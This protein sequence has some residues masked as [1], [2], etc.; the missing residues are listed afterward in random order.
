MRSERLLAFACLLLVAPVVVQAQTAPECARYRLHGLSPGMTA[1]DVRDQMDE[2]G[3]VQSDKR[4]A[5]YNR[6]ESTIWVEFDDPIG[7]KSARLI[8]IRSHTG[9]HVD[10]SSVL[11]S[12]VE[13]LGAVGIF[14]LPK[15]GRLGLVV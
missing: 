1:R 12:L 2:K 6:E 11:G 9:S 7:K 15:G 3:D 8:V 14:A 5:R 4:S 13:Q 10:A